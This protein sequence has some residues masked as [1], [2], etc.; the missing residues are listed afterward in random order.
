M[1]NEEIQRYLKQQQSM[2]N[3]D[4]RNKH[5][6]FIWSKLPRMVDV[7]HI[8]VFI[9]NLLNFLVCSFQKNF[10][11]K[12]KFAPKNFGWK[13]ILGPKNFKSKC[14]VPKNFE[15]KKTYGKKI[16]GWKV[17]WVHENLGPKKIWYKKLLIQLKSGVQKN[18]GSKKLA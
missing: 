3:T 4:T 7:T 18:F 11:S 15:S 9:W 8:Y 1:F 10:R 6:A 16:S 14:L 2:K 13:I 17:I 12:K 5:L